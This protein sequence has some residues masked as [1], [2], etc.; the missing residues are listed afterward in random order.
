MSGLFK[1]RE[2]HPNNII[3]STILKKIHGRNNIIL[4]GESVERIVSH[5]PGTWSLEKYNTRGN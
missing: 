4:A 1:E 5:F 2:E 3:M